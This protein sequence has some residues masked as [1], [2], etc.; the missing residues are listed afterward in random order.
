MGVFNKLAETAAMGAVPKML[1][2]D[3][4][5]SGFALGIVPGLLYK[6]Q[7]EE[8]AEKRAKEE[9]AGQMQAPGGAMKKGGKV[10]SA[11]SRADGI[12]K[13]GKTRGKIY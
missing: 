2:L 7:Y 10:R 9:S 6:D 1:G 3:G 13:R 5:N 12:A 11:S 4:K 8:D